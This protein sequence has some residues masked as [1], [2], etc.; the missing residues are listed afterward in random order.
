VL[1]RLL[2]EPGSCSPQR[3]RSRQLSG[4]SRQAAEPLTLH[5][6]S[7]DYRKMVESLFVAYNNRD[8]EAWVELW[9]PTSEW[10]P[11]LTARVEGDPG[12][13][14]HNGMRAW[15]EDTE[16]MFSAMHAELDQFR[17]VNG[18]LLVLGHL[19]AS[20]R[21]GAEVSSDVAWVLETRGERFQRG[22]A[23]GSHQDAER[24]AESLAPPGPAQ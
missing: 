18:R 12:Y 24:Q 8:P 3:G 20:G 7:A 23:Y 17:E 19:A 13:H 9:T 10:H 4:R 15:F 16:E 11:F 5:V 2:T 22:W 21:A 6:V 14:G 1:V